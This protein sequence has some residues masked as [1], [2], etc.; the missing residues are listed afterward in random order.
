MNNRLV[1]YKSRRKATL[2]IIAGL[3]VWIG[4]ELLQRFTG[5]QT[6]G[7][8]IVIAAVLILI[9]GIGSFRDRKPQIILTEQGITE[10]SVLREEIEWDA[11]L[12]T[13]DFFWRGQSFV[14]LLLDRD[15]KPQLVR[16]TWF[17]R[18][19]RLYGQEGVKAVYMR[20]SNLEINS[21]QLAALIDKMK[22]ADA[23]KRMEYLN[24]RLRRR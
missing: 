14:R 12:H 1:I 15:Y 2:V 7:W 22:K 13:D 19:D 3:L 5:D 23:A 9:F 24:M 20:T 18:L 10:L 17:W 4:G 8:I 11:I 6:M 16:P 21:M